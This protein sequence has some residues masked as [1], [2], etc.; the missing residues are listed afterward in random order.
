M[1]ETYD[2]KIYESNRERETIRNLSY[3]QMHPIREIF[4]RY[5]IDFKLFKRT[6]MVR[7][8]NEETG[9]EI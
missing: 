4:T 8:I 5:N 9:K 3:A 2:I 1:S 6:A 7:I